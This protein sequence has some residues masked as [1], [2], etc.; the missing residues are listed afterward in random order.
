MQSDN[1]LLSLLGSLAKWRKTILYTTVAAF[2]LSLILSF[3][4]P[5]Y[6]QAQT[7][8]FAANE[9][10]AAPTPVGGQH[11]EYYIYGT[12]NDRDRLLSVTKSGEIIDY[13]INEFNLYDVYEIDPKSKK[14]PFEIRE[15]LNKLYK[16][17]KNKF[18]GIEMSMEDTDPQ[19]A[20]DIANGA[21]DQVSHTVQM[22]IKDSQKKMMDNYENSVIAKENLINITD[23][24]LQALRKRYEIYDTRSQGSLFARLLTSTNSQMNELDG[25]LKLAAKDRTLRD[26]IRKWTANLGGLSAKKEAL[27]IDLENYNFGI[28]D[29]RKT[30][31]ELARYT[32]QITFDKERYNQLKATYDAPFTSIHVIEK[33]FAPVVKSRPKKSLII[34]GS[35]FATFLLLILGII[36][37]ESY[38]KIPW[39]QVFKNE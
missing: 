11:K 3:F 28:A 20:A 27:I 18:G 14:G 5:V 30:E 33:A 19:R 34:L 8:F 23:D 4:V 35:T 16:V 9:S 38:K 2:V 10:L 25:K 13:I 36:L 37:L 22:M 21:R 15:K 31:L 7:V 24:S 39:D 1:S 32:D 12:E 6:Y 29:V 26:S 17:N